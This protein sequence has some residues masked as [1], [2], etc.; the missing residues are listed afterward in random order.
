M[1]WEIA[2]PRPVPSPTGLVV[3][4]GSKNLLAMLGIDTGAVVAHRDHDPGPGEPSLDLDPPP[5]LPARALDRL[6]SVD[7][8]V[9][10]DLADLIGN[11]F[12]LGGVVDR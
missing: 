1:P 8:Q 10:Q 5:F 4:N 7:Q 2:R 12:D 11:A 3:K 6:Q 9:E